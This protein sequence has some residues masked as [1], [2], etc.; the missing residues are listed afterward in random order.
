MVAQ[1]DTQLDIEVAQLDP[2]AAMSTYNI[3]YIARAASTVYQYLSDLKN[4]LDILGSIKYIVVIGLGP[5][6]YILKKF[7]IVKKPQS[8]TQ[9]AGKLIHSIGSSPIFWVLV[10]GTAQ[11][12][13][14]HLGFPEEVG[15]A[16]GFVAGGLAG[17]FL[18][19]SGC[20]GYFA[21]SEVIIPFVVGGFATFGAWCAVEQ[22][23]KKW[24]RR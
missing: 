19:S 18:I 17:W 13:F 1:T 23:Q 10:A 12:G 5:G 24:R 15:Q 20:A 11:A 21:R 14:K 16:A 6:M 7:G 9:K 8:F 22:I 2:V 3:T 4:L